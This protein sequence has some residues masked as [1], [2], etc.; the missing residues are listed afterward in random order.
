MRSNNWLGGHCLGAFIG[1]SKRCVRESEIDQRVPSGDFLF[2]VPYR[3]R[4][5]SIDPMA[6]MMILPFFKSAAVILAKRAIVGLL[7]SAT[8]AEFSLG[9]MVTVIERSFFF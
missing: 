3:L 5:N 6:N 1:D 8:F 2:H 9:D 7:N 4:R